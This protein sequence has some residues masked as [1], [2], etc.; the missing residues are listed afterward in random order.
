MNCFGLVCGAFIFI[1]GIFVLYMGW[2]DEEKRFIL[3]GVICAII[4][5][6]FT[7]H[8]IPTDKYT[9]WE[10]KQE[11][12]VIQKIE[13]DKYLTENESNYIYKVNNYTE[14][15]EKTEEHRSIEKDENTFVEFV[16]IDKDETASYSVFTRENKSVIGLTNGTT[17]TKYVFYI[18]AE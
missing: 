18:P 13:D 1:F 2:D 8:A 11:S 6:I 16:E 15:G 10:A 9:D 12:G 3:A 14:T 7:L 5:I 4:G 17:Q